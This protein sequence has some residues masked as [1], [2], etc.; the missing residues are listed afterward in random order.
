M[1]AL[2]SK[3]ALTAGLLL[4]LAVMLPPGAEARPIARGQTAGKAINGELDCV[5]RKIQICHWEGDSHICEWVDG[6]CETF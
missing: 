2:L 1:L 4:S 6:P 3:S 5:R